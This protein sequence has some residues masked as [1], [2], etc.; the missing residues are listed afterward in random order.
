METDLK[1][2]LLAHGYCVL[3]FD[4]VAD[5]GKA[6]S[7]LG[8]VYHET[9]IRFQPEKSDFAFGTRSVPFHT[10]NP[11]VPWVAWFCQKQDAFFGE[12]FLL[13]VRQVLSFMTMDDQRLLTTLS[14]KLPNRDAFYPLLQIQSKPHVSYMPHIW[15]D[16]EAT[17]AASR[18]LKQ[19]HEIVLHLRAEKLYAVVRLEERQALFIDNQLM[20]HA[21]DALSPQ[22]DRFLMRAYIRKKSAD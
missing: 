19:F 11:S 9:E 18:A 3:T 6:C 14:A 2:K 12:T 20:L 15:L 13:D 10:D 17:G 1:D 4:S 7:C 21:R 5:F 22:S 16:A 8:D